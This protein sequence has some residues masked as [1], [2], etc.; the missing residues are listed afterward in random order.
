MIGLL[1]LW[2]RHHGD[3]IA[4]V[5]FIEAARPAT[6]RPLL[7]SPLVHVGIVLVEIVGL[8]Q[9]LVCCYRIEP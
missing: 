2:S 8:V 7:H 3:R 9:A 1:A 4:A 5:V 6:S